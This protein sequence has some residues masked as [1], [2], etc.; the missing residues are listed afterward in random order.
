MRRLLL[1]LAL[2]VLI[3]SAMAAPTLVNP[4][5]INWTKTVGSQ[6]HGVTNGTAAQDVVTYSQVYDNIYNVM[7]YGAVGDGI[8]DDSAA[9]RAALN[10]APDGSII[11]F[12]PKYVYNT[13]S[14]INPTTWKGKHVLGY[15]ATILRGADIEL[16]N[17]NQREVEIAGITFLADHG[18]SEAIVNLST[19]YGMLHFHDVVMNSS[20]AESGGWTGIKI[21]GH[22]HQSE[23]SNIVI[24]SPLRGIYFV[25]AAADWITDTHWSGLAIS[26]FGTAMEISGE[27]SA[28]IF[29]GVKIMHIKGIDATGINLTDGAYDNIFSNV[30]TWYDSGG[31][32]TAIRTASSTHANMFISGHVEGFINDSGIGNVIRDIEYRTMPGGYGTDWVHVSGYTN[33]GSRNFIQN[34]NCEIGSTAPSYYETLGTN[35]VITRNPTYKHIGSYSL[36][37]AGQSTA[38]HSAAKTGV[39]KTI[40]STSGT[41]TAGAWVMAPS[42][43]SDDFVTLIIEDGLSQTS[44]SIIPAD[45]AWHWITVQKNL[46]GLNPAYLNV[47]LLMY[48]SNVGSSDDVSYWDGIKLCEGPVCS[49][50]FVPYQTDA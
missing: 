7:S 48:T 38:G 50:S 31:V 42:T 8:T 46:A 32:F 11:L 41:V 25:P 28:N 16:I 20:T 10:A 19:D 18:S 6:I 5:Q 44:S 24:H 17:I 30:V 2:V 47:S 12:P 23:F 39:A 9:I 22:G 1:F 49:P 34:G 15:G 43:N 29:D 35:T 13:C 37:V 45:G 33:I 21:T 14:A 3:G 27:S 26:Q 40:I 36:K 4:S